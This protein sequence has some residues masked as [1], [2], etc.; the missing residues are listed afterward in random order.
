MKNDCQAGALAPRFASAVEAVAD[1]AV[2]NAHPCARAS[3]ETQRLSKGWASKRRLMAS[4]RARRIQ[5]NSTIRLPVISLQHRPP[6]FAS[7][8]AAVLTDFPRLPA[9]SFFT[10][11]QQ[12]D[13]F[14]MTVVA[15]E[16]HAG[17]LCGRQ[18]LAVRGAS[19]ECGKAALV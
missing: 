13:H 6:P 8:S 5:L 16:S 2:R 1:N 9:S 3:P 10:F 11:V 7:S 18:L 17:P 14:L 19:S 15:G 4:M 12:D